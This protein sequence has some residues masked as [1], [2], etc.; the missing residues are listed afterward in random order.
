MINRFTPCGRTA[1][2]IGVRGT[3]GWG[4]GG[5]WARSRSPW[6]FRVPAFFP[7][8]SVVRRT[9]WNNNDVLPHGRFPS[10]HANEERILDRPHRLDE[11]WCSMKTIFCDGSISNETLRRLTKRPSKKKI[12][13]G[14]VYTV[15]FSFNSIS[16]I[17][18]FYKHHYFANFSLATVVG[19]NSHV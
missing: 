19:L 3:R 7:P 14:P 11:S 10:R 15:R 13:S 9:R 2:S 16:D 4:G 6:V 1:G 8:N 18:S 17:I 5:G 12:E